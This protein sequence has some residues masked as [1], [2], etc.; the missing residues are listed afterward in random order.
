ME[1]GKHIR[2]L[3]GDVSAFYGKAVFDNWVL[4]QVDAKYDTLYRSRVGGPLFLDASFAFHVNMDDA[5]DTSL[6]WSEAAFDLHSPYLEGVV[7]KA[8]MFRSWLDQVYSVTPHRIRGILDQIPETW[9][10]P[11]EYVSSLAEFLS[12]SSEFV[13]LMAQWIDYERERGLLT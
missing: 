10:V 2:Q 1:D 13:E 11:D 9:S 4:L 8:S 12:R 5:W 7:T 6:K 3:F